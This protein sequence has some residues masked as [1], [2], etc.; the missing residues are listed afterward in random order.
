MRG[1]S[2]YIPVGSSGQEA[3]GVGLRRPDSAPSCGAACCD[4]VIGLGLIA[5]S[6][7]SKNL[8]ARAYDSL[9]I[10][11]DRFIVPHSWTKPSMEGNIRK[12]KDNWRRNKWFDSFSRHQK[13]QKKSDCRGWSFACRSSCRRYFCCA[14]LRLLAVLWQ[15]A[16]IIIACFFWAQGMSST[17]NCN[18]NQYIYN[19]IL[20]SFCVRAHVYW[21]S[22]IAF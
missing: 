11:Y 13:N 8:A 5:C 16:I 3:G 12:H 9:R 15:P 19:I 17:Y 1:T 6:L 4:Y 7:A 20:W 14:H 2:V 21:V 10:G 22:M 18:N